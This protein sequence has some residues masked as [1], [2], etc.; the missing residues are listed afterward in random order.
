MSLRIPYGYDA[1]KPGGWPAEELTAAE[2]DTRQRWNLLHPEVRRRL[3]AMFVAAA[4]AGRRLGIGGGYRSAAQQEA[5]FRARYT[6]TFT[7]GSRSVVIWEGQTWYLLP[8]MAPSTP[9]SRSYHEATIG[10]YAL[11]ADLIGDLTWM[12]EHCATFGLREF[13]QVNSEPWHVQPIEVPTARRNYS[14]AEHV[15]AVWPLPETNHGDIP[16]RVV[17]NKDG[18]KGAEI[19]CKT[20]DM[21]KVWLDNGVASAH[22][23]QRSGQAVPEDVDA[24]TF[25]SLGPILGPI[26][27]GHDA[28]GRYIGRR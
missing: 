13:S 14:A 24:E 10:I 3:M 7:P 1:A 4:I 16:M 28:Y 25:A 27:A 21:I 2:L 18:Q 20:D 12:A 15:L 19:V 23:L 17:K 26:P 8:G 6:T 11:A 9:P 5:T 22:A